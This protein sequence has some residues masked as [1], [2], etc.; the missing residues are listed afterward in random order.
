MDELEAILEDIESM[1][2]GIRTLKERLK[3]IPRLM[4][5]QI[6]DDGE[7]VEV[8]QYL[9]WMVP[10]LSGS[11]IS[12]GLLGLGIHDLKKLIGSST[13]NIDCDR[14]HNPIEFRSRS[15]LQDTIRNL[16]RTERTGYARYAEGYTVICDPCWE[17]VQQIRAVERRQ[18][19]ARQKARLYE[20]KTMPYRDYLR[21]PEWQER[22]KRHIKSAGFRCQVCNSS[23]VPLDVHHRTYE[24]RGDEYYKDLL[25]L[26]R[27]CHEIFH[28]EGRLAKR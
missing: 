18:Q 12:E 1:E 17:E 22:R 21:T 25:A 3:E 16:R 23:G 19:E 6:S 24:R 2:E 14:C 5:S 7:L 20:L 8:A 10:E 27:N 13:T 11:A 4:A 28:R 26:C 15:H 9:Y